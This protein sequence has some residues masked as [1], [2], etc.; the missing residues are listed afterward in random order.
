MRLLLRL[1]LAATFLLAV[2]A[3]LAPAAS[4]DRAFTSRFAQMARG[5]V[6][7]V[8][9]TIMSC[10]SGASC[11]QSRAGTGSSLNNQDFTM[12]Y[13]DVD[14]DGTTFDSSSAN[15]TLPAGSTVLFA[16]LYWGAD[17]SAGGS[18]LAAPSAAAR[19]TVKLAVPAGAYHA[20]TPSQLDTGS[21]SL[22]RSQGFL[23]VRSKGA[24][25][26]SAPCTRTNL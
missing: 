9:N 11:T 5:D 14:S 18:G 3:S 15:L 16:G 26:G 21:S 12:S 8:A 19:N 2:G 24:S 4:A 1:S 7:I 17:T 25:G 20:V 10:P 13:V 6:T 22:T 23:E